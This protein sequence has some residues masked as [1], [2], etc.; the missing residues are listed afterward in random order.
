[1]EMTCSLEMALDI[2][3]PN[4]VRAKKASFLGCRERTDISETIRLEVYYSEVAQIL[5][6]TN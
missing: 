6:L 2:H 5:G 3:M 1:M 4:D